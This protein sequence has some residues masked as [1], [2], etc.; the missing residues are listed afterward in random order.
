VVPVKAR[1]AKERRPTFS[2]EALD[3]FE[4]LERVR[5]RRSEAF[6]DKSLRLARM[7]GLATEWWCSVTDV[8]ERGPGPVH[9]EGYVAREAWFR[10]RAVRIQLLQAVR[11]RR[12]TRKLEAAAEPPPP[13]RGLK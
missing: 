5:S 4:E 7:L 13:G 6:R 11:E 9:P 10:C 8:N 1:A 2:A 12:T 3:L